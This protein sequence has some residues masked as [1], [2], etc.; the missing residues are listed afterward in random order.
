MVHLTSH[1]VIGRQPLAERISRLH[2][3][4]YHLDLGVKSVRYPVH[5]VRCRRQYVLNP[6][7]FF[8]LPTVTGVNEGRF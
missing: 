8:I 2:W 7:Y 5:L 6:N 4:A 3:S 1:D